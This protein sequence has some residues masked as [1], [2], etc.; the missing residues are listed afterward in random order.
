MDYVKDRFVSV[1]EESVADLL[2]DFRDEAVNMARQQIELAKTETG[3]KVSR[4]GRNAA[5]LAAGGLV[6][7]AGAL[8]I[9]AA[10][11]FLGYVGLIAAGVSPAVSIWLMPLIT[12]VI[13]A[14][15]GIILV[16]K[17]ISTF[18]NTSAVPKKTVQSLK[19]DRQ[20]ISER[21]K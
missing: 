15:V 4:F 21:R 5:Y 20:W 1:E 19:E 3:E 8:F 13:V 18:K 2:R 17:A 6:A 9:L 16:F 7:Y 12:G 11:T 14:A 10:L